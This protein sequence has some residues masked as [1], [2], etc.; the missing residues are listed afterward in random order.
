MGATIKSLEVQIGQLA[1]SINA[2]QKGKFPSDTKVNPKEQWKAFTLR[3]G[4]EIEGEK[5]ELRRDVPVEKV[6]TNKESKEQDEQSPERGHGSVLASETSLHKP[7][8][9]YPQRFQKKKVDA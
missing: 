6:S 7:T 2:Q 9:P 4:K 1:S 5:Q 3:S 8:L